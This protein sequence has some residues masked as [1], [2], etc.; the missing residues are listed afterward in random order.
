MKDKV[1]DYLERAQELMRQYADADILD[2]Y[3][4]PELDLMM[5][6]SDWRDLKKILTVDER[7]AIRYYCC[8]L[9]GECSF[10]R[11]WLKGIEA[12]IAH[13]NDYAWT[14]HNER[15]AV[16]DQI[17]NRYWAGL[18]IGTKPWCKTKSRCLLFT[19]WERDWLKDLCDRSNKKLGRRQFLVVT[20]DATKRLKFNR[21]E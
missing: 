7:R 2:H 15:L 5:K 17:N 11:S 16:Y 18:D 6:C 12:A 1:D 13:I 21:P 20:V 9:R 14:K 19:D 4:H 3:R 10:H 8:H